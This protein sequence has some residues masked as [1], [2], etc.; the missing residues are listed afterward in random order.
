MRRVNSLTL[1]ILFISIAFFSYELSK[2]IEEKSLLEKINKYISDKSDKYYNDYIKR[3]EKRQK[4]NLKDKINL[5]YKMNLIIDKSGI[6]RNI[7][8]NPIAFIGYGIICF[9]ISYN[10]FFNFFKIFALSLIVSIPFLF[11][12]I[13]IM[14][15]IVTQKE[16]KLEKLF[17][18]FLLQLKN[19]TQINNDITGAFR[20]VE[21]IEPLQTYI[22]KFNIEINSGVRFEKAIEHLKEKISIN[23]FKEFFSIVQ[24]CYLYGGSF[25][26]LIDKNYKMISELQ[27]E[28]SKRMQETKGARISLFILIALDLF[29]YISYI[30]SNYE[31]YMIMQK[32]FWGTVILYWNF[33]SMLLLLWLSSKVKKLDY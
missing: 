31:N 14:N 5:I 3:N 10:A 19:Y 30:N 33:I 21:T 13:G 23:K 4:I 1:I 15:F 20:Q 12:P 18:N 32:S 8:I 24:Y 6:Q 22:K 16:E 25:T 26:E 2:Y 7:F 27:Q 9:A 17:L 28:K 11:L 29:M